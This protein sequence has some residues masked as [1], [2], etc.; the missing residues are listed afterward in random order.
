MV[1]GGSVTPKIAGFRRPL[2]RRREC[3]ATDRFRFARRLRP[4]GLNTKPADGNG[5][6]FAARRVLRRGAFFRPVRR[7]VLRLRAAIVF[8]FFFGLSPT[9]AKWGFSIKGSPL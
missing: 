1:I 3:R 7:A 5:F 8:P 9:I 4:R 2:L 6:R